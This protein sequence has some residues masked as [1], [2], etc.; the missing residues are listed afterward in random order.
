M[1]S[2]P[3][4][5]CRVKICGITSVEQGQ[6]VAACGADAIGLVFFAK[7][8]R[9]VDVPMAKRICEALP[10][11]VVPV[12]LFVD[13]S[14]AVVRSV[15]AEVPLGLLQFHG[16]ESG[17]YCRSFGVPYIKAV[18]LPVDGSLAESGPTIQEAWREHGTAQALLLDTQVAGV[19]G[20]TGQRFSLNQLPDDSSKPFILA[21]GLDAAN[22]QEAIT[23]C[24]PYAVDTSSGVE[25]V[26]GTKDMGLVLAFMEAV[27]GT[28][29]KN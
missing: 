9:S 19:A 17:D 14:E 16:E 13:E 21:G 25:S 6:E 3:G 11:F 8:P 22:V 24:R 26:P 7:S 4:R 29:I 10:P 28:D 1:P 27:I 23:A 2:V 12:G 5:R 15:L 20:G 18:R